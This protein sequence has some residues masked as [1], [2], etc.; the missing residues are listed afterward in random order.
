LKVIFPDL[1]LRQFNQQAA[2]GFLAAGK[3]AQAKELIRG[4]LFFV[5]QPKTKGYGI[6]PQVG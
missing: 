1:L 5:S 3:T 2:I 4:M 6:H